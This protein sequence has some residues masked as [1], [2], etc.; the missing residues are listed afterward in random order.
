MVQFMF[1]FSEEELMCFDLC[2]GC[3]DFCSLLL[4]FHFALKI[5]ILC[6]RCSCMAYFR[7]RISKLRG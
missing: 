6:A 4:A 5:E 3:V 7:N 1:C 2:V